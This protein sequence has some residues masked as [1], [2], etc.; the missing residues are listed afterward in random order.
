[1]GSDRLGCAPHGL[2]APAVAAGYPLLHRYLAME[3]EGPR[4]QHLAPLVAFVQGSGGPRLYGGG[5]GAI[6]LFPCGCR[7]FD[8]MA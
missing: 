5:G 3:G 7:A 4:I 6:I 8:M 1:M 2:L